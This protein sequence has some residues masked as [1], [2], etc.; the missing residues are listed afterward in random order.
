MP[1]VQAQTSFEGIP[2]AYLHG[3]R[4]FPVLMIHGSGPGASTAGNWMKVLEPLSDFLEIYAMDLIG[5]GRS[6]RKPQPPY[7]DFELW[8][9]QCRAMLGQMSGREC[10]VIGHSISGA[11]A[12]KLAACE[13]RITKVLTTGCM[14]APFVI[15]EDTVRTWT[16]PKDDDAL[17]RAAQGLIYDH[18]LID[19]AYLQARRRV[20]FDDPH[21]GDYFDAMFGGDKRRPAFSSRAADPDDRKIDSSGRRDPARAVLAFGRLRTPRQ[22][23]RSG[24]RAVWPRPHI[25]GC[26][27]ELMKNATFPQ[28]RTR[29]LAPATVFEYLSSH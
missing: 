29:R 24:A 17:L 16:F 1:L 4:G 6:G 7:F 27:A 14:G 19:E 15:N 20:L 3:G 18:S 21:Y 26:L 23:R 10:G 28:D 12:L 8:L 13:P 5:F 22:A 9:R 2:V 25:S 11:L